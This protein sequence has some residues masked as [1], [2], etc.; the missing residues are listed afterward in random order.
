MPGLSNTIS[1]GALHCL[2]SGIFQA[3]QSVME[4]V[5]SQLSL[6]SPAKKQLLQKHSD[7]DCGI[8]QTWIPIM[9]VL[10]VSSWANNLSEPQFLHV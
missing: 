10:I 2:V 3:L 1:H 5:L 9:M 8:G 7:N 6:A 4:N